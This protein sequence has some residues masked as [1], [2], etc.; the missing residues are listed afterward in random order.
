MNILVDIRGL[1]KYFPIRGGVFGRPVGMVKA[2]DGVSLAVERGQW[3]GLVGESGCGKTTLAKTVV[4]LWKPTSGHIY[5]DVPDAVKAE[6]EASEASGNNSGKLASLL[7]ENDLGT[8]SGARVRLFRRRAQL[9]HQDPF[10]SLDPRMKLKNIVAEPLTIHK[11]LSGDAQETAVKELLGTVGLSAGQLERYPHQFSGGQRQRIAIARAL[12][13]KP[14]FIAF[15][16]PT[17]A[18]DVS[19]QAQI[20]NLLKDLKKDFGLT[21]LYIT[22]ELLIAESVCDYIAVMYL[23]KVVEMGRPEE[24]F[25]TPRHPYS[26]SLVS[27][28]PVPDPKRRVGRIVLPGEV[29]SPANPPPGCAFH[30]RCSR[31][32]EQCREFGPELK[33]VGDDHYVACFHPL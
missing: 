21:Y 30:P 14:E 10:T 2:V 27:A 33:L 8:F 16:E 3:L 5:F 22:H 18:L 9:V 19:V 1:K 7:K 20:L 11:V 26:Q 25:H 4:R 15:D 32:S 29:P 17:S 28:T 23:G 31:A 24:V 6:I 13:T 12:A